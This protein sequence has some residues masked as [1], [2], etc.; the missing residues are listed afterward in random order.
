MRQKTVK[1]LV[2]DVYSVDTALELLQS[3]EKRELDLLGIGV[4]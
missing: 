2:D 3:V 1:C 4:N